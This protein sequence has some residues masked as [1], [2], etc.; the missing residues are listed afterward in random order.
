MASEEHSSWAGG[1]VSG[2]DPPAADDRGG[3]LG[4]MSGM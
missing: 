1:R 2:P 3:Q 4:P